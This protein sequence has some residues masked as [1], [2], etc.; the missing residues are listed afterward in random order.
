MDQRWSR[1]RSKTGSDPAV[2]RLGPEP[3]TEPARTQ[4]PH[5]TLHSADCFPHLNSIFYTFAIFCILHFTII[6][7]IDQCT[8]NNMVK[9]VTYHVQVYSIE[10]SMIVDRLKSGPLVGW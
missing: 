1:K 9:W 6:D 5:F 4:I 2:N 7:H 8:V 3:E 10:H